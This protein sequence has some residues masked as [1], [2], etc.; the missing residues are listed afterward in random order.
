MFVVVV[1]ELLSAVPCSEAKPWSNVSPWASSGDGSGLKHTEADNHTILGIDLGS[2]W[3]KASVFKGRSIEVVED[4]DNNR[5]ELSAVGFLTN[6]GARN[7]MISFERVFG[8]PALRQLYKDPQRVLTY[9][10]DFLGR[11]SAASVSH[12]STPLHPY[13]V[14]AVDAGGNRTGVRVGLAPGLNVLGAEEV[15]GMLLRHVKETAEASPRVAPARLRDC[16]IAVR[17]A[18]G[19]AQE[20]AALID[21]ARIAGLN[22]LAVVSSSTANAITYAKDTPEISASRRMAVVDMGAAGFEVGV[23]DVTESAAAQQQQRLPAATVTPRGVA[24]D[25]ALGGRDFAARLAAVVLRKAGLDATAAP[26]KTYYRAYAVAERVMEVLSVNTEALYTLALPERDYAGKVTRAEFEAAAADLLA[27]VEAPV[28]RALRA[29]GLNAA[30][31]DDVQVVGGATRIPAVQAALRDAF[32]KGSNGNKAV[33]LHTHISADEGA[34]TGAAYLGALISPAARRYVRRRVAVRDVATVPIVLTPTETVAAVSAP[35]SISVFPAGT[36]LGARKTLTL[37]VPDPIDSLSFT[38]AH[39]PASGSSNNNNN[40]NNGDV[41]RCT[42]IAK[43][44]VQL[45]PHQMA[46]LRLTFVLDITGVPSVESAAL[47]YGGAAPAVPVPVPVSVAVEPLCAA[48]FTPADLAKAAQHLAAFDAADKEKRDQRKAKNDLEEYLLLLQRF[49]ADAP[50]VAR[51]ARP[52]ELPALQAALRRAE[53]WFDAYADDDGSAPVPQ[54][55]FEAQLAAL[56]ALGDPILLRESEAEARPHAVALLRHALALA[57]ADIAAMARKHKGVEHF[58]DQLAKRCDTAE[59][60]LN[61][62]LAAQASRALNEPPAF[63]TDEVDARLEALRAIM[64]IAEYY[65]DSPPPSA[66]GSDFSD[67][68]GNPSGPDASVWSEIVDLGGDDSNPDRSGEN[69]KDEV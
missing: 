40:N 60:W 15:V 9:V 54:S 56:R 46:A 32:A 30:D 49:L 59:A 3:I 2:K 16:V 19:T 8:R 52:E 64:A 29:A 5:K 13:E 4:N 62:A 45:P 55:E 61:S 38:L 65:R 41:Q 21:A 7:K 58:A 12:G 39:A 51:F 20:R 44:S 68:G 67:S 42:E 17:A 24:W 43:L 66:P 57:R 36:V 53:E 50:R 48:P 23:F 27:R 31:I 10:T 35:H 69:I 28:A 47:E 1:V 22:V 25:S 63:L 14:A 37:P 26:T 33:V 34:C 18:A 6:E 11:P